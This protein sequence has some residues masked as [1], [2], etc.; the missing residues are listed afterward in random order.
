MQQI[1]PHNIVSNGSHMH[2]LHSSAN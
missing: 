2:L 1:L